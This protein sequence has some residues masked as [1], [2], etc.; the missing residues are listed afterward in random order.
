MERARDIDPTLAL[1]TLG[2]IDDDLVSTYQSGK[3]C[4]SDPYS[5]CL[6]YARLYEAHLESLSDIPGVAGT[7]TR[8]QL[9]LWREGLEGVK[10]G[11]WNPMVTVIR[12]N[13]KFSKETGDSEL[14][15]LGQALTYLA[16]LLHYKL[17]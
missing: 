1:K 5:F 9:D 2:E 17:N 13:A 12:E 16:D 11:N 4:C 3:P 14:E 6:S 7:H 15:I 10:I 8:E